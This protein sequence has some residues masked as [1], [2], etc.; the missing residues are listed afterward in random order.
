MT[1]EK[2]ETPKTEPVSKIT[3]DPTEGTLGFKFPA[4]ASDTEKRLFFMEL[5][6]A[7]LTGKHVE[8]DRRIE[9]VPLFA[10]K[11]PVAPTPTPEVKP[12]VETPATPAPVAATPTPAVV[13]PP[14]TPTPVK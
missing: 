1:E 2:K 9:V 14:P 10:K 3:I 11:E 8:I 6:R 13:V 4:E 5:E 12:V 7:K